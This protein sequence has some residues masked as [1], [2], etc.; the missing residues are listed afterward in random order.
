MNLL[1]DGSKDEIRTSDTLMG[2]L[3]KYSEVL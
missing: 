1:T 2:K 3:E